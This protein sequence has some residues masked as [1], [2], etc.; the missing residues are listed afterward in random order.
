MDEELPAYDEAIEEGER[1]GCLRVLLRLGRTRLGEP[2][3]AEEAQLQSIRNL[4]RL[5][6]LAVAIL[7]VKSWP[8]LLATP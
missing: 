7:S 2:G 5:M 1:R 6:R 8:E 3:E 4:D